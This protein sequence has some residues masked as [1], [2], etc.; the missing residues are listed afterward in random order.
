[1]DSVSERK[2][3]AIAARLVLVTLARLMPSL[4]ERLRGGGRKSLRAFSATPI[5]CGWQSRI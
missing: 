4:S 5:G 2:M 1:M 3:V